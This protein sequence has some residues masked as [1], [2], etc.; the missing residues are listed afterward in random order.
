MGA[1]NVLNFNPAIYRQEPEE[2]DSDLIMR[3]LETLGNTAQT[4]GQNRR[5]N[6]QAQFQARVGMADIQDKYGS[7]GARRI[8]RPPPPRRRLFGREPIVT[9]DVQPL[10]NMR[11]EN[12]DLSQPDQYSQARQM[13]GRKGVAP[14]M[15]ARQM[16]EA[17]EDR[18]L[19]RRNTES[20]IAERGQG[21]RVSYQ[22]AEYLDSKGRARLGRFNP[23]SGQVEKSDQDPYA[24]QTARGETAGNLRKEFIDRPEVKEFQIIN[25]QVK[26]MDSLLQRARAGDLAGRNFLDQSL[27]TI[28]NK[29][30][31]PTSVVRES[32]YARTPEG[33]ALTNR[34]QGAVEKIAQG[35]AGLT[36][37]DR[38]DL[39]SA[40]K[41]I[42]N[43]RGG[44]YAQTRSGYVN[45]AQQ[46]TLDPSL[47]TATM[48]EF[49]PYEMVGGTR[50]A[51]SPRGGG[52]V[53]SVGQTFN[54]EKVIRVRRVR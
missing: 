26:S 28:F 46:M 11:L 21:P 14:Y 47:I 6:D 18:D 49:S 35:G 50:T 10:P 3:A 19:A 4:I 9:P 39:V 5:A 1:T 20:M 16:G 45:L 33:L 17:Q 22:K 27:I 23:G 43:T 41:I 15:E 2:N 54:G 42:A 48:P 36:D 30:N 13:Y 40:A 25:T 34:L 32:E 31:D 37:Q 24:P 7:V 44:T 51:P 8:L 38:E 52:Q 29:I 53:P 12:M